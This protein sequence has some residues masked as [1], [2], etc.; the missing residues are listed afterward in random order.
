MKPSRRKVRLWLIAALGASR[1][2][3]ATASVSG[4]VISLAGSWRFRKDERAVD[5]LSRIW[6]WKGPAW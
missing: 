5:R 4:H 2:F 1:S 6:Y 3:V